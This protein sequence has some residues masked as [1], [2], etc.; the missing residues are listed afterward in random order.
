MV[1]PAE[2]E[3]SRRTAFVR[4]NGSVG[5]D[6]E[7][8][9]FT[10]ISNRCAHLGCPVQANG[11]IG[12]SS[13]KTR[14]DRRTARCT[15]HPDRR[16]PASAAR[17]TAASTT[18]RATAPPARRC[19]RSTAT[20]RDRQRQPRP[21]QHV[22]GLAGRRH[23]RAGEDPQVQA[24]RPGRARRRRRAVALSPQPAASLMAASPTP[25]QG[26]DPPRAD[27]RRRSSTRSTGSR[28]APASSAASSTSSS[29]TSRPTRTGCRRS[30][31]RR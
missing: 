21:A 20:V 7:V 2:G 23:R 29:A 4:N 31:R 16:P 12:Q 9:S 25:T 5:R 11:P 3:V 13:T 14:E 24:R 28:S 27:R 22:L 1:D 8:P 26:A 19:A 18:P 15:L 10:I 17:A 6:D 30:A